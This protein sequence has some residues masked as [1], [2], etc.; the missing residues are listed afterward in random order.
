[1]RK[2][3]RRRWA[4]LLMSVAIGGSGCNSEDADRLARVVGAAAAKVE[5][6]SLD[7]NGRLTGWPSFPANLDE[8]P[9][10]ARVSARLRWDQTLAGAQIQVRASPEGVEL[11]GTVR[12]LD[13]RRRAVDLAQSTVG[14]ERVNDLL[15]VPAQEP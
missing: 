14:T 13:Q 4:L 7:A 15:E 2:L 8:L 12:D 5:A 1:M 3:R 11:K 6:L 9:L 10:E